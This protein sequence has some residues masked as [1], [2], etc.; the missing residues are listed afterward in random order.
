[1]YP[2]ALLVFWQLLMPAVSF[3]GHLGGILAGEAYV[4]GWLKVL[5]PSQSLF[6]VSC[7]GEAATCNLD[8]Y[9]LCKIDSASTTQQGKQ[10]IRCCAI[11]MIWNARY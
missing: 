1:M 10:Q 8:C 3:W 7:A 5:V 9:N 11:S 6:Q 2:W 4:R